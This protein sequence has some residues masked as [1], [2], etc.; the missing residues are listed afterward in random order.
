MENVPKNMFS[1]EKRALR[2][3]FSLFALG[4]FF[5]LWTLLF[6]MK[7]LFAAVGVTFSLKCTCFLAV[8]IIL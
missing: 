4:H 6:A 2:A 1:A 7:A 8:G 5:T 3:R